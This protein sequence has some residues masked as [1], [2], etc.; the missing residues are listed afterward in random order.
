MAVWD[1][2]KVALLGLE[3]SGALTQYPDPRLDEHREPPFEIRLQ[4]W[5]SE[6]V[7]ELP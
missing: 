1:V 6:I 4:W 2:C 7:D 5:A 3:S